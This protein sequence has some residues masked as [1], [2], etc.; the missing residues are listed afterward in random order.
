MSNVVGENLTAERRRKENTCATLCAG[1]HQVHGAPV[2]SQAAKAPTLRRVCSYCRNLI[3]DNDQ[4][5]G[6]SDPPTPNDSHGIC[7]P[8]F[9]KWCEEFEESEHADD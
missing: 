8:C 7:K 5:A 6:P 4:P 9:Q 2:S 3:G 1:E